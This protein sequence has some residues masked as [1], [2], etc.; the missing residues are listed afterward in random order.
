MAEAGFL[1]KDIEQIMRT[2]AFVLKV[3]NLSFEDA[4]NDAC[5][6]TEDSNPYLFA[7]NTVLGVNAATI[8]DGTDIGLLEYAMTREK[9]GKFHGDK[10][11]T[12][13]QKS[14]S[15]MVRSQSMLF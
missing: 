9:R 7:A 2:L 5:R 14:R 10:T 12:G 8:Q 3:G 4:G 1:A 15:T 6:I 11:I 13:A